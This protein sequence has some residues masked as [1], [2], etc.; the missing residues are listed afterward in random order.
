MAR[1]WDTGKEPLPRIE[2]PALASIRDADQRF[3][4]RMYLRSNIEKDQDEAR[5]RCEAAGVDYQAA[6]D[7]A[8][9]I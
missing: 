5:K 2:L 3:F 9:R 1:D 4:L 7:E 6:R 8:R